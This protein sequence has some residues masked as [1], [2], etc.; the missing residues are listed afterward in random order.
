MTLFPTYFVRLGKPASSACF[1]RPGKQISFLLHISSFK[2]LFKGPLLRP[3]HSK[4]VSDGLR[5][6]ECPFIVFKCVL[7][8]FVYTLLSVFDE[9]KPDTTLR[10]CSDEKKR[11][12]LEREKNGEK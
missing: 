7:E 8:R 1:I 12:I 2:S 11:R 6:N 3:L 9:F 10:I 5:K 4:S